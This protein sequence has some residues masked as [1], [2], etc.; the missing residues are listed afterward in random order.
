M[1]LWDLVACG[2]VG[3]IS[4]GPLGELADPPRSCPH[5]WFI[6]PLLVHDFFLVLMPFW[7]SVFARTT[8]KWLVWCLCC[9]CSSFIKVNVQ[10]FP[11]VV[12][13]VPVIF[14]HTV[15]SLENCAFPKHWSP[16]SESF[17]YFQTTQFCIGI[18]QKRAIILTPKLYDGC[19]TCEQLWWG[20][21]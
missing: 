10:Q 20:S 17:S 1:E 11:Q 2:C 6:F 9:L 19:Q 8:S 15:T 5:G 13:G 12:S 3:D 4:S 16:R 14:P 18:H 7:S 21:W